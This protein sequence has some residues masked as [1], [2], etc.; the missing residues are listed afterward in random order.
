LASQVAII[1]EMSPECLTIHQCISM[2]PL[3]RDKMRNSESWQ[4]YFSRKSILSL[5]QFLSFL[6]QKH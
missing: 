1:V 3:S 6:F 4:C 2:I 5:K